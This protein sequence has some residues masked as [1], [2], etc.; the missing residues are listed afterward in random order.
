MQGVASFLSGP[1]RKSPA[2]A[3]K[4]TR[5]CGKTDT[6]RCYTKKI[7]VVLPACAGTAR[8]GIIATKLLLYLKI[9]K[10]RRHQDVIIWIQ[11]KEGRG[12]RSERL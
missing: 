5:F 8:H 3:L 4:M 12:A 6:A 1:F 9:P 11:V 10:A 2:R 7:P